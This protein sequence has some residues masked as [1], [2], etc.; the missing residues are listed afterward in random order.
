MKLA[1]TV[2]FVFRSAT[3]SG[4]VADF[5]RIA[6]NPQHGANSNI[7]RL[8]AG[9]SLTLPSVGLTHGGGM[10]QSVVDAFCTVMAPLGAMSANTL[11]ARRR[12][13]WSWSAAS[14]VRLLDK[15][16]RKCWYSNHV[17]PMTTT[18]NAEMSS[19]GRECVKL[20]RYP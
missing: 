9:L 10:L 3:F 1:R 6:A 12:F 17:N 11:A 13:P 16:R 4:D 19:N 8:D 14:Y 5:L 15:K 7:S 18:S 20:Y 2:D